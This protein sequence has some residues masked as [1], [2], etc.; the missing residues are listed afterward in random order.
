MQASWT[1]RVT[2][3][4]FLFTRVVPCLPLD[5]NCHWSAVSRL[6][7]RSTRRLV[8]LV[9][10]VRPVAAAA[11]DELGG[12]PG[13]HALAAVAEDARPVALEEGDVEHPG[14]LALG[15]FE[16]DPLVGV[17]GE[18]L[19]RAKLSVALTRPYRSPL[20]FAHDFHR[21]L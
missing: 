5:L 13:E 17:A 1:R 19:S 16:T 6:A 3:S 15:V 14:A 20:D 7:A 8:L 12:G 21:H 4:P 11:L 9:G 18:S 10:E 2:I